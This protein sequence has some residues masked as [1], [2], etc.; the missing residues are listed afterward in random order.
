MSPRGWLFICV[1]LLLTASFAGCLAGDD[2][3][4]V[5]DDGS[6]DDTGSGTDDGSGSG[7]GSGGGDGGDDGSTED[8]TEPIA[9]FDIDG[10]APFAVGDNITF[11]AS[12]SEDLDGGN[13]T[14][15]WDLGDGTEGTG[16]NITHAYTTAG[17]FTVVLT[18]TSEAGMDATKNETVSIEEAMSEFSE[19]L[20]GV[21]SLP[22]PLVAV[23]P[24]STPVDD[25]LE[26]TDLE[27]YETL[28]IEGE[29]YELHEL[30]DVPTDVSALIFEVTSPK[31]H[32]MFIVFDGDKNHIE[33]SPI[34]WN[35]PATSK[36]VTL[37]EED[38]Q[39]GRYFVYVY[40]LIHLDAPY[41]IDV[42]VE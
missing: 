11:D 37:E 15:A 34:D 9:L 17:N 38:A 4:T 24:S 8:P 16:V 19:T 35:P 42:S 26:L 3:P 29:T 21:I 22:N 39:H 20:G 33:N 23:A 36:P 14:F 30:T 40:S 10:P 7:D 27:R 28:G 1:T 18:V 31:E 2:T 41:E 12:E 32:V 6:D 13:L 25:E 5:D